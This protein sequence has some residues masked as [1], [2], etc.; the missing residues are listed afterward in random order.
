MPTESDVRILHRLDAVESAVERSSRRST[1]WGI[2][3]VALGLLAIAIALWASYKSTQ[4]DTR[5]EDAT[6][7]ISK[8][9]GAIEDEAEN[10]AKIVNK[11]SEVANVLGEDVRSLGHE[12]GKITGIV[13][14]VN[15]AADRL[16]QNIDE[17]EGETKDINHIVVQTRES[18]DNL[19]KD[20]G[21]LEREMRAATDALGAIES[22]ADDT[23]QALQSMEN[24]LHKYYGKTIALLEDIGQTNDG[25]TTISPAQLPPND[26]KTP[27]IYV[28]GGSRGPT[29]SENLPSGDIPCA[30][31]SPNCRYLTVHMTAFE[32]GNYQ[33]AC[34]HD[35]WA[36]FA[37]GV[38]GRYQVTIKD[39]GVSSH[40]TPCFI[41]FDRLTGRGVQIAATLLNAEG[42]SVS[43][44]TIRSAWSNETIELRP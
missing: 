39:D 35:G 37:S 28:I 23:I 30:T 4:A 20:V 14:Q 24:L 5:I 43:G 6:S 12:A 42:H 33:M 38:W 10:I 16:I 44:T 1:G 7:E 11:T 18:T 13:T 26:V 3:S 31:T 8:R 2:V 29:S 22:K 36:Q 17:L 41:N 15:E 25:P 21:E 32:A 19:D 34:V 27:A 40:R 9:A